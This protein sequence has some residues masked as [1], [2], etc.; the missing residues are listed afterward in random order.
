MSIHAFHA[1][2]HLPVPPRSRSYQG[3]FGRLFPDLP[4]WRPSNPQQLASMA[5]QMIDAGDPALDSDL[6]AGYTYFGQF[7]DHDIT[8][9]PTP[10][11]MRQVDPNRLSNFRTPRLDLDN[12]YGCGPGASPHL[13]ESGVARFALGENEHGELDLPRFR[14]T[15]LIG[16]PRNDE[17][18]IVSQLQLAFLKLHNRL[19]DH[20]LPDGPANGA[21]DDEA[22]ANSRRALTWLYQHIVWHDFVRR[23]INDQIW[24]DLLVAPEEDALIKRWDLGNKFYDW[25]NQPFMPVE[26]SVAAYRFGHSLVR[27]SYQLNFQ[28]T[29]HNGNFRSVPIFDATGAEADLRGGRI[30]P[31]GHTLQWD[32]FLEFPSSQGGFPQRTREFDTLLSDPLTAIPMPPPRPPINLALANL[33]RGVQM[34]LPSGQDVARYMGLEPLR[35]GMQDPLWFYIL[36]EAKAHGNGNMLGRVGGTIVGEVFAGLLYSDPHSY[37]KLQPLWV[38]EDEPLF[39]EY[40]EAVGLV[41]EGRG[42]QLA[43]L[44]RLAGMPIDGQ[45]IANLIPQGAP[46]PVL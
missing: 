27:E 3:V 11:L 45:D 29:D 26:F 4:A 15:A 32:W 8:F 1:A 28:L 30:L 34:G 6:P 23:L 41:D 19:Y 46:Q 39:L 5:N 20:Q 42:W 43:D 17:N 16:D 12:V 35:A 36:A 9:D 24:Q 18:I 7:I 33:R 25:R 21:A 40:R 44:I 13:Y 38:P 10:L 37:F 2:Q 22:F 31:Q 14:G